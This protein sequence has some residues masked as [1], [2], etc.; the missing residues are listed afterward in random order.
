MQ[1]IN[2][3]ESCH[4]ENGLGIPSSFFNQRFS[5]ILRSLIYCQVWKQKM[6]Y[7]DQ[8]DMIQYLKMIY[9]RLCRE[10]R[11]LLI[12]SFVIG[13]FRCRRKSSDASKI[14]YSVGGT[15]L[16]MLTKNV[17]WRHSLR[18]AYQSIWKTYFIKFSH[19]PDQCTMYVLESL[20]LNWTWHGPRYFWLSSIQ[21]K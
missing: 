1:I 20:E 12:P 2:N 15:D 13:R 14:R 4:Q 7:P 5:R 16:T 21:W 19:F 11:F 3:T 9:T 8:V 17:V 6:K 10:H 18:L